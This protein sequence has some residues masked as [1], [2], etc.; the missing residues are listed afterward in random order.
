[1]AA[2]DWVW[3]FQA[4]LAL[5][6]VRIMLRLMGLSRTQDVWHRRGNGGR[7]RR[8]D[9]VLGERLGKAVARAARVHPDSCLAQSIVAAWLLERHGLQ[10]EVH[11]GVATEGGFAAHAWVVHDG[12]IVVG[13]T[14]RAFTRLL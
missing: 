12:L 14:E 3:F 8:P 4:T 5:P 11:I 6:L 2:S 1:M 10:A 7:R 9:V 13:A